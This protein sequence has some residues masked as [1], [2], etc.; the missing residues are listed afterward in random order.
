[1]GKH[2]P[3]LRT[4][5]GRDSMEIG[6]CLF[7]LL[8]TLAF[9]F[10]SFL[11][12]LYPSN[13][14]NALFHFLCFPFFIRQFGQL[15]TAQNLVLGLKQAHKFFTPQTQTWLHPLKKGTLVTFSL[16][17]LLL[18]HFLLFQQ[19]QVLHT[20]TFI[21]LQSQRMLLFPACMPA[22]VKWETKLF[23][24]VHALPFHLHFGM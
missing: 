10:S 12:W 14:I 7:S 13:I 2:I 3:E 8:T 1:M 18:P 11:S 6:H 5:K 16:Q 22:R 19:E 24:E 9:V 17:Y 20:T 23:P 15:L 4:R 21:F